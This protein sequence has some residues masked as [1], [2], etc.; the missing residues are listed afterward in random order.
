M[1][2]SSLSNSEGN[3]LVEFIAFAVLVL[4]PVSSFAVS[5]SL[6]WLR[7]AQLQSAA[8]LL[9]RAYA[10]GGESGMAEQRDQLA[11][12]V[13]VSVTTTNGVIAVTV[14]DGAS[15]VTARSVQ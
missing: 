8:S 10:I 4:V 15:R 9:A 3:A 5:S 13:L 7:K 11:G 6:E 14:I 2:L 1:R 12:D